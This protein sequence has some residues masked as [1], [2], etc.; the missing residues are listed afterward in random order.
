MLCLPSAKYL[1]YLLKIPWGLSYY[2]ITSFSAGPATRPRECVGNPE[3]TSIRFF[4]T[5]TFLCDILNY[6]SLFAGISVSSEFGSIIQECLNLL[7]VSR[8]IFGIHLENLNLHLIDWRWTGSERICRLRGATSQ[9]NDYQGDDGRR[10]HFCPTFRVRHAE[11][12][13]LKAEGGSAEALSVAAGWAP[14]FSFFRG[15]SGNRI[16]NRDKVRSGL[17][18]VLQLPKL[19]IS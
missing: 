13:T 16:P 11:P 5:H 1:L 19:F 17:H 7:W 10:F 18:I 15:P 2:N 8:W 9:H 3:K 4:K 6:P 12:E 14:W